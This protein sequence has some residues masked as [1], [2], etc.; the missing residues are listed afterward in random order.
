MMTKLTPILVVE[1]IEPCLAYWTG[2][3]GFQVTARV[4]DSGPL[5]FA[6]LA[7]DGIE[8]MYQTRDALKEDLGADFPLRGS[9]VYVEV[10]DVAAIAAAV[11]AESVVVPLRTTFY[12]ATEVFVREPGGNV[13]GFAQHGGAA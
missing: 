8:V 1:A 2:H 5:V 7:R 11:P 13:V 4:P 9:L 12:G 3:L 10:D 6:I